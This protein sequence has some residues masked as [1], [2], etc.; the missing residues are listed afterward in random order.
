MAN[1]RCYY[2]IL[3]IEKGVDDEKIKLSFRKL[4]MQWHP[5]RNAGNPDAEARFRE[6][7]EA[8]E[9]LRDQDKRKRYD[10]YGFPGIEASETAD[11]SGGQG[12][13][14]DIFNDL[15]GGSGGRQQRNSGED[16]Q[17]ETLID[18]AEAAKGITRKIKVPRSESCGDCSGSGC[19][20]GSKKPNAESVMAK[21]PS[22]KGKAFFGS[23]EPVRLVVERAKPLR[24]R[25]KIAPARGQG[26]F[27]KRWKSRSHPGWMME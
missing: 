21:A 24:T 5:D 1:R 27:N 16:L 13:I 15:F 20:P 19:K 18:L 4:A 14:F 10:R 7:N 9:V 23:N 17:I 25:A 8:Y 22:F 6:V 11:R 12:S 3:E 2:E 26:P